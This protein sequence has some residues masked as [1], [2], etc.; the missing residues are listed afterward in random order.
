MQFTD[1]RR[2]ERIRKAPMMSEV[3]THC[4]CYCCCCVN[5]G[6]GLMGKGGL[7]VGII[8]GEEKGKGRWRGSSFAGG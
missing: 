3:D 4:S 2:V 1:W 5:E 8:Y 7:N 6:E